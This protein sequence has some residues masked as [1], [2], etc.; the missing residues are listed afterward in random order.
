MY[1][2]LVC[3]FLSSGIVLVI[4]I[5]W[6]PVWPELISLLRSSSIPYIHV[7]VTIKPFT[8]AFFKFIEF[9]DTHDVALIFQN[10]K[11]KIIP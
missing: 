7:D 10:E 3:S 4:D 8:R 2:V 6:D 9:T 5:T 11:R 1:F